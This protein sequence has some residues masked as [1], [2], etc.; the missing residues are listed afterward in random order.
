MDEPVK[1]WVRLGLVVLL[2]VPQLVTGLWAVFARKDFYES[3][4]GVDPRL[5]AAEPPFNA[6][7]VTDAGAGFLATGLALVVA[8]VLARRSGVIVALVAYLAFAVPHAVYHAMNPAPGLTGTEDVRNVVVLFAGV[9]AALV[10]A[11]GLRS[12]RPTTTSPEAGAS[13]MAEVAG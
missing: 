12:P 4:P 1:G 13:R 8:A 5:V 3:F 10:L 9:V 7:L 6:H 11:W 2:A